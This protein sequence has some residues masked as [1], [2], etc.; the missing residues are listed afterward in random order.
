MGAKST[1]VGLLQDTTT[2]NAQT[3][4]YI[5]ALSDWG[6]L[7]TMNVGTANNL[8]IPLDSSV[9]F[10]IGTRVDVQQIGAGQT[11][12]VATGGV[13]LTSYL[14][15]VKLSGQYAAVTLIKTAT[16]SWTIIGNLSA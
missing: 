3:A 4:S 13:T 2:I 10:Q 11:T 7:V 14:S 12:I 9:P 5:L 6:K 8:T 15:Y 1:I 16:N